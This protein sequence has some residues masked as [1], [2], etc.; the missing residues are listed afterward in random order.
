MW[1]INDLLL[2]LF[3]P[4]L[5]NKDLT[6]KGN[7]HG[8]Q[9]SHI[10]HDFQ[11]Q[12][13]VKWLEDTVHLKVRDT[14]VLQWIQSTNVLQA[15]RLHHIHKVFWLLKVLPCHKSIPKIQRG[16]R[17]AE[18]SPRIKTW[19]CKNILLSASN[20]RRGMHGNGWKT[21]HRWSPYQG[22]ASLMSPFVFIR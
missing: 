3:P 18:C 12:P 19:Y 9:G 4:T 2:F 16:R 13:G 14:L 5:V 6:M 20:S 8:I 22:M 7:F 15:L 11:I 10:R 21:S 1:G 17:K